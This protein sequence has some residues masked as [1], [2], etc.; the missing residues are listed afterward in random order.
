MSLLI[1]D[2]V[3]ASLDGERRHS[4]IELLIILRTWFD[5]ILV[6]SHFEEINESADR[7]LRVRRNPQTPRERDCRGHAA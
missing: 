5:Q 3:F 7:C 4:V 2:E 1:L 6:I